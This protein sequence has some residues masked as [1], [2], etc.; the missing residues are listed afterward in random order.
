MAVRSSLYRASAVIIL[1]LL[2]LLKS[3]GLLEDSELM[4]KVSSANVSL[5]V[6]S[7]GAK[8]DGRT[9]DTAAL[10]KAFGQAAGGGRTVYFPK[11]TYLV[12]STRDLIIPSGTTVTGDGAGSVIKAGTGSFGWELLRAAGS[13]ITVTRLTLDGNNQVNRVLVVAG[14]SQRVTL[15]GLT[16]ANASQSLIPGSEGY[17]EVVCGIV[18]YGNTKQITVSGVEVKNI[19]AINSRTGDPIARGIYITATWGS[20][21]T[22]ARQVSIQG[23]YIHHVGPADDGDGIYFEDPGMDSGSGQLSDSVISGN[24]FDHVAKRGIKIYAEGIVVKGN[25]I[26][27]SYLNNNRYQAGADKGQLAPDMYAAISLYGSHLS[28]ENNIIDGVGSYYAAIEVA[29]GTQVEDIA[30]TGNRITMGAGSRVQ[31]TTSIRLGS[32]SDF[33]ISGNTISGGERGIWTWQNASDGT[34]SSNIITVKQGGGID[35]S[36][37]LQGYVQQNITVENNKIMAGTFTIRQGAGNKNI[38]IR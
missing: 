27:N 18:I 34:I 7:F 23:S 29:A 21:E 24:T 38:V 17:G 15:S 2:M 3:S 6:K 36:T 1:I 20:K 19:T 32:L 16:V 4:A 9:N 13:D 12:D 37:Y 8:G 31:G 28:A 10:Q 5:N 11:G 14:G 30:I 35:L 26:T 22:V 33:N 25:H